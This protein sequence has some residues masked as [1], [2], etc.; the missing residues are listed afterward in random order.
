MGYDFTAEELEAAMSEDRELTPDELDSIAGGSSF[1][2][3][4]SDAM[5][6]RKENE[7]LEEMAKHCG[8][9]F[10]NPLHE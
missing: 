10:S 7:M 8:N 3:R 5:R 9:K 6:R 2:G 4:E 1:V